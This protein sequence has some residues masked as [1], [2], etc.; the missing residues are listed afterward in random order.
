MTVAGL[1]LFSAV[2]TAAEPKFVKYKIDPGFWSEGVAIADVNRDGKTDIFAGDVWF[3]QVALGRSGKSA[4]R[5]HE[6]RFPSSTT[7]DFRLNGGDPVGSPHDG[8]KGYCHSFACFAGDFNADN[9]TDFICVD[10]PGEPFFWFEN[11]K[12]QPGHW[13]KHV[14]WRS[15]C[16]ETPQFGDLLGD[17]KPGI[18]VGIQPE[19][20]VAYL[21]PGKDP[22]QMWDLYELSKPK[23]KFGVERY[24]HG[25]GWGDINNDGRRDV[26]FPHGWLEQPSD[27]TKQQWTIHESVLSPPKH[28]PP[29]PAKEQWPMADLHVADLDGD[30]D[31]DV[32]GSSAHKYGIWWFENVGSKEEPK[33]VSHIIREDISETHA[34]NFADVDGD[35]VRDI[36]TGKRYYSHMRAE[37]GSGDPAYL[38]WIKVGKKEGKPTFESHVI[39]DDS[40]VGTQF[41]TADF[42]SDGKLDVVTANKKGVQLFLQQ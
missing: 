38:I 14:I 26:I 42:N 3:E 15:A 4:W 36:I 23:M 13:K 1:F 21:R 18:C 5:R 28:N 29:Q 17:G 25:L 20:Q 12:G 31:M 10:F 2:A 9:W 41:V 30:N 16:N 27:S 32:I 34:M 6:V 11:P 33:F 40:G 37:P 22:T 24:Y 35:G 39:D 8:S 19:G 7:P